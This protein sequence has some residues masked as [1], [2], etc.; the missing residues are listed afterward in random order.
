MAGWVNKIGKYS[1]S[2]MDYYYEG[3]KCEGENLKE[4]E[5]QEIDIKLEHNNKEG[6]ITVNIKELH[7]FIFDEESKL[8][9]MR[10]ED[11]NLFI[12]LWNYLQKKNIEI[13]TAFVVNIHCG[14]IRDYSKVPDL[15]LSSEIYDK[16][17]VCNTEY[18]EHLITDSNQLEWVFER[19]FRYK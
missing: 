19:G 12:W 11:N 14:G 5:S 16:N 1:A 2:Q 6:I 3:I 17:I 10:T 18:K 8:F 9:E 13:K 7:S 4:L 15:Y